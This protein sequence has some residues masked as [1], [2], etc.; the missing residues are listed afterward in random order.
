MKKNKISTI[1]IAIIILLVI[2]F[3]FVKLVIHD[4]SSYNKH[5]WF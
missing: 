2:V 1:I 3:L 4:S 5:V